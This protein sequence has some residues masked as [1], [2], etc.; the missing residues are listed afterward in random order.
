MKLN[1]CSFNSK[2]KGKGLAVYFKESMFKHELDMTEELFQLSVFSSDQLSLL[3]L[4][5]SQNAD[6]KLLAETLKDLMTEDK[7]LLLI[8]DFNINFSNDKKN[9]TL[10]YLKDNR[11]EQL[12][13]EPTH[14]EGNIIDQA[15]IK[16]DERK[17]NY[18]ANLHTMYFTD[19][20]AIAVLISR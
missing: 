8:G 16:D 19:H 9:F 20:R 3:V 7:P 1:E 18:K 11:L 17:N 12:I 5:R 13:N 10:K 2:G 6:D 14:I 15:L 4:Y